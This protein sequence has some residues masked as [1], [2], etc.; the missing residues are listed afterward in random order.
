M[1]A[2]DQIC[3]GTHCQAHNLANGFVLNDLLAGA[4]QILLGAAL[5]S[6]GPGGVDLKMGSHSHNASISMA[7]KSAADPWMHLRA[8]LCGVARET[9]HLAY[10]LISGLSG[11]S[12][13]T[14]LD[15]K[16]LASVNP[17]GYRALKCPVAPALRPAADPRAGYSSPMMLKVAFDPP[18]RDRP[19][20]LPRI[21]FN[22]LRSQL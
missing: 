6:K 14:H 2:G 20:R 4:P 21:A 9:V 13:P 17:H 12:I 19:R 22:P 11:A 16:L 18:Q 1:G 8:L 15:L 7:L 3:A 5:Y 10:S